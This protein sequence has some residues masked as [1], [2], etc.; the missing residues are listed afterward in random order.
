MLERVKQYIE[1]WHMLKSEDRVIVGISGGADSVCLVLILLELQKEL[2]FDM[3]GVHVNHGLRGQAAKEDEE[4]VEKLCQRYGIAC[5]SYFENVELIAKKRKQSTEEAGR[6]VRRECFSKAIKKYRGT[7]IALAHHQDDSAETMLIHLARGTGLRGLGGIA[8]VKGNVIRPLLCVRRREIEA[9]LQERKE[10]YCVD[11]T[12]A[13]DQYTRNRIRNHV[14]PYLEEQV[15]PKAI[16]HM[17]ETMEQI[18]QVQELLDAWT[19]DAWGKCV[20]E[21][22]QSYCIDEEA[23]KKVPSVVQSLLLK[24]VMATVAGCEK[25]LEAIHVSQIQELFTKQ[26]GRKID[27]PYGMEAKRNY[28]G[29]SVYRREDVTRDMPD[30]ILYDVAQ[31]EATFHWGTKTILCKI[32]NADT[33]EKSSAGMFNCD[34]IKSNISFRTRREGDYITIHPDGRTQKLKSYLINEKIP[35][36][37]RDQLLLVAEGSHVLWIVG[38]RKSSAYQVCADT[39]RILEISVYEGEENGR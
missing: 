25:D 4:F 23:Y 37:E 30:E 38:Y 5:E 28:Q 15:N 27:L 14:L 1:K 35:Q 12:N 39:K 17:N 24:R 22:F 18:R 11:D 7:K 2:G 10:S 33:F 31:P 32:R 36:S 9:F 3:V 34:I 21:E 13:S 29:I 20:S 16:E 19:E 6:E 26:T 8:P